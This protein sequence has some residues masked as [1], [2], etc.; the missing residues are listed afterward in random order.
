MV[1]A[2]VYV[3]LGFLCLR[4]VGNLTLQEVQVQ[5][6]WWDVLSSGVSEFSVLHQYCLLLCQYH[7]QSKHIPVAVAPGR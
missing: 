5:T 1:D 4:L 3:D 6:C 7:Q 2:A